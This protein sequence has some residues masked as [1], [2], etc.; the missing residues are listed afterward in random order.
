[1]A[2]PKGFFWGNSVSSMQYDGAQHQGGKGPS[3]YEH[4]E[5][6]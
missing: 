2:L 6:A 3:V 5:G 1:M 4:Y